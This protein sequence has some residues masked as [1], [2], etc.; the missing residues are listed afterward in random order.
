MAKARM[1]GALSKVDTT[2]DNMAID[3]CGYGYTEH[4]E[5]DW[6]RV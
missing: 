5:C 4:S 2:S 6:L 1:G 3:H